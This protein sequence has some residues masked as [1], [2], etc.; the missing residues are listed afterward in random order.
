MLVPALLVHLVL[1]CATV[2]TAAQRN[3]SDDSFLNVTRLLVE[4]DEALLG[5]DV[6]P[7][8]SWVTVSDQRSVIQQSY[9]LQVF[10]DNV[11]DPIWDSGV[12][13][14]SIPYGHGYAGPSLLSD[15]RY[16]WT[17]GVVTNAGEAI[18]AST[19]T[20]GFMDEEEWGD[21]AWIGKS[22]DTNA[23]RS[24]AL[25]VNGSFW[26]WTADIDDII[27][28]PGS[29][30]F[31]KHIITPICKAAVT[32]DILITADDA[33]ILFVNGARA[34][35]ASPSTMVMIYSRFTVPTSMGPGTPKEVQSGL[36]ASVLI[37]YDDGTTANVVSDS[38]WL[39]IPANPPPGFEQPDFDES[40]W[41]SATT[42][43][44][45][46]VGS[47]FVISDP[48]TEHP[49]PLW[50]KEFN[51]S[52][53]LSFARPYYTVGGFAHIALN[54]I[55]ASDRVLTPGF[56][57]YD[58]KVQSVALN[59]QHLLTEGSNVIGGM[60][61]SSSIALPVGLQKTRFGDW[62][63]SEVNPIGGNPPE[64]RTVPATACLYKMVSSK[65]DAARGDAN[66]RQSHNILAVAFNLTNGPAA[67]QSA[68]D[69]IARDIRSRGTHMNTGALS[70]KQLSRAGDF[71]SRMAPQLSARLGLWRLVLTTII[72]FGTFEDTF[73]SYILGL[74]PTSA[75]FQSVRIA[76]QFTGN[77]AAASG[78]MLTPFGNLT[79]GYTN[80][81]LADRG[82]SG[83]DSSFTMDIE[84][85]VG[86]TATVVVPKASADDMV[87]EG[88]QP[89]VE[90]SDFEIEDQD[91]GF[92][93]VN[94]GPGRYSFAAGL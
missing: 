29:R 46:V 44:A 9:R 21:S 58:A 69:C 39:T 48:F 4:S 2:P 92:V 51:M 41:V 52:N 57:N 94:V 11:T 13:V 6:A 22:L 47:D 45:E 86:V 8:F 78:W 67:T 73:Y 55:P 76:P 82:G 70:T 72:S 42:A 25:S 20:T 34:G 36:L 24:N 3:D 83:S 54:D 80:R 12:I 93:V 85:P 17:V 23:P 16:S 30:G 79:I 26:I 32:A 19:L 40:L 90:G 71:G 81:S 91:D 88:G 64:N 33:F 87:T 59:V 66:Y 77:L 35:S 60:S 53:S 50:R 49:A 84:V 62:L 61:R 43:G 68:V 56:T 5:L 14:S 37:E 65:N 31:R 89:L 38:S 15:T 63:T 74:Q 75:A 7:R 18:G 1:L 28:S 27:V 10:P